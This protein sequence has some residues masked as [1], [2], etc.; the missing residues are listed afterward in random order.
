MQARTY[1][2]GLFKCPGRYS[3]T[4]LLRLTPSAMSV[5]KSQIVSFTPSDSSES[6]KLFY[7]DAKPAD[8]PKGLSISLHPQA[9]TAQ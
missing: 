2:E 6:L 4:I 9:A 5:I 1:D 8:T 3:S 7:L